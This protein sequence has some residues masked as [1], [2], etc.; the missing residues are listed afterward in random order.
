MGNLAKLGHL[1]IFKTI[2]NIENFIISIQNK[3]LMKFWN[4]ILHNN[5]FLNEEK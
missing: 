1:S 5:K 3:H 2:K 4:I